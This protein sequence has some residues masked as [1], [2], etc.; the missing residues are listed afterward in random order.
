MIRELPLTD[1]L[2]ADRAREDLGDIDALAESIRQEGLL[3][4]IVVRPLDERFQLIAGRRRLAACEQ[5]GAMTIPATVREADDPQALLLEAVE[6]G[7]RKSFTPLEAVKLGRQLEAEITAGNLP[8]G[9]GRLLDFVAD[10]VGMGRRTY[11]KAR[12]V[13]AYTPTTP[14]G[15]DLHEQLTARLD[16]GKV[17]GVHR[18]LQAL[19]ALEAFAAHDNEV[20]AKRATEYLGHAGLTPEIVG[21]MER[22]AEAAERNAQIQAAADPTPVDEHGEGAGESPAPAW[23]CRSCGVVIDLVIADEVE[24]GI[25][26]RCD[27]D[28][29][30]RAPYP[31]GPFDLDADVVTLRMVPAL[32]SGAAALLICG[33]TCDS[34]VFVPESTHHGLLLGACPVCSSI[35][36]RSATVGGKRVNDGGNLEPLGSEDPAPADEWWEIQRRAMSNLAPDWEIVTGWPTPTRDQVT[37]TV[38]HRG[39]HHFRALVIDKTT[40]SISGIFST[41]EDAEAWLP[42]HEAPTQ[43]GGDDDA[44]G[45]GSAGPSETATEHAPSAAPSADDE[46]ESASEPPAALAGARPEGW[47]PRAEGH[48]SL[49]EMQELGFRSSAVFYDVARRIT[50]AILEGDT[51]EEAAD[52]IANAAGRDAL[53]ADQLDYVL[54]HIE[55]SDDPSERGTAPSPTLSS[56]SEASNPHIDDLPEEEP[57]IRL[58]GSSSTTPL[59]KHEPPKAPPV[60]RAECEHLASLIGELAEGAQSLDPSEVVR[61]IAT[62]G[63]TGGER[64]PRLR[65]GLTVLVPFL[66]EVQ[67]LTKID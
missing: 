26:P 53:T 32:E 22:Y 59:R 19:E 8:R 27:S 18:E 43:A 47:P 13:L 62:F 21:R 60:K 6:N 11:E 33:G 49:S 29:W 56:E 55:I 54:A 57:E 7:Q 34:E 42:S 50:D 66:Q 30:Y 15:V 10:A 28:N 51:P 5:L 31:V 61:W 3:Q 23:V 67:L 52:R 46:G 16:E 35:D 37:E 39:G 38:L 44:D 14:E 20:I 24:M 4:P 36:W 25:C 40:S 9:D 64:G 58:S 41:L 2:V 48:P 12:K 63:P 45:K 17:D 65:S 1:V